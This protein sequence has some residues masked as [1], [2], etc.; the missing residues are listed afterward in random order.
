[1]GKLKK[2]KKKVGE[3]MKLLH[4]PSIILKQ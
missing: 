1:M 2:K 4:G 3:E